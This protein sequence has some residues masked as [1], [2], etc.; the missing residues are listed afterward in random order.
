MCLLQKPP[1]SH[2]EDRQECLSSPPDLIAPAVDPGNLL[3][4]LNRRFRQ[5]TI[6][7]GA[8]KRALIGDLDYEILPT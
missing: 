2:T 6:G 3:N 1:H 8:P 5:S 4:P 7:V